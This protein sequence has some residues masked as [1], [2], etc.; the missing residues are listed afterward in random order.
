[1]HE[2]LLII[3]Q[4]SD[5]KQVMFFNSPAKKLLSLLFEDAEGLLQK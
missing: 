2:G 1:M 3:S 5:S 4:K